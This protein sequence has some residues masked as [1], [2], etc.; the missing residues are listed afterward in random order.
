[1]GLALLWLVAPRAGAS[2]LFGPKT[3]YAVGSNARYVAV[4]KLNADNYP[5]LVVANGGSSTLSVLL[6]V[7]DG[8]FGPAT[9]FATGMGPTCVAVA[10]VNHDNK[11]DAVTSNLNGGNISVLLGNGDGT[12]QPK[13]D[14]NVGVGTMPSSGTRRADW[15]QPPDVASHAATY[16][17]LR[18]AGQRHRQF[19]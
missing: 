5:D 1:M 3:D 14:I 16:I 9:S 18:A 4:A 17:G 2:T 11:L 7:G 15:R 6:G 19:R 8:T 12:F 10:D 13:F